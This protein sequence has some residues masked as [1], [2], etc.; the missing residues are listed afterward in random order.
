LSKKP[1]S[2]TRCPFTEDIRHF[3][4]AVGVKAMA[5]NVRPQVN[6]P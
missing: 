3:A 1:F 4:N 6:L 2:N 5:I